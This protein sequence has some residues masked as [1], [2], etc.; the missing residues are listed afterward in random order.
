M[1]LDLSHIDEISRAIR[2]LCVCRVYLKEDAE[3]GDEILQVGVND[4]DNPGLCMP[5][6]QLFYGASS[7]SVRV[8]EPLSD[9]LFGDAGIAHSETMTAE[10]PDGNPLHLTLATPL[11]EAYTVAKRAYVELVTKPAVCSSLKTIIRDFTEAEEQPEDKYFPGLFVTYEGTQMPSNTNASYNES[12]T[13]LVRYAICEQDG[14]DNRGLAIRGAEQLVNL[15]MEDNY[16]GG[17]VHESSVSEIVPCWSTKGK[18]INR[19]AFS[20][21]ESRR[22]IWVDIFMDAS[23]VVVWDKISVV[24]S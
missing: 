14:V 6:A 10:S 5:G 23:R 2:G 24:E 13:F 18:M 7:L 20:T 21:Q 12:L 4:T 8:V 15:L 22:I 16:L 1:S 17:T 9:P 3:I 19:G 11:T